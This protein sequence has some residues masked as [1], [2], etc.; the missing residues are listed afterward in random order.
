VSTAPLRFLV[1]APRGLADL[2]ARE[3]VGLGASDA[4]ER[5][6]GVTFSGPLAVAY[7]ACLW[8][9]VA[10]RVFLE[11][12]R[13]DAADAEVFYRAVRE[14][15]WTDHVGP[16]ATLACDFS[17]HHPA[18]T[19]THFGALKLKDAI[20]DSVRE[21]RAWRP[22][23]ELERPSVRVH[24][25]ANGT[26][27]TL[28]LDLSGE[29]LHRRGYRGAAGE[30]PLKENVAAGVLMRAGWA[31]M[32][33]QG[34]AFLDPM[35]GSGTFVIEAALIAT[36]R[37]PG[38]DRDYFGFLGWAGHDA[39]VWRQVLEDARARARSGLDGALDRGLGGAL[40]GQD[41]DPGAIR[42]A[43]ANAGRAGVQELVQFD[44][45]ALKDAAPASAVRS[46][47]GGDGAAG[48]GDAG[49]RTGAVEPAAG[50]AESGAGAVESA[51]EAVNSA[52]RAV[53]PASGAVG[54]A[55][56]AV[57]P[58]SGAV[59]SVSGAVGGAGGLV[60]TNPPYGVRLEDRETARAV[61]RELGAVLR[62][63]FQGWSAAVLTGSP[64]FGL[65]LGIRAH[66]T[67]TVWNGAIECR[68]LRMKIDTGSAREPGR[69]GKGDTNLRD[70]P[71]ARMFANRLAKNLKKQQAWADRN[72]I[73][74][75]RLYD[76][77]MPEYAFAI[78]IYRTIAEPPVASVAT[79][80]QSSA[81][82]ASPAR[83]SAPSTYAA[84]VAPQSRGEGSGLTW[85]YVQEYA[86]PSEIELEAVR[87]RRGEALSTLSDVTGVDPD[88]IRIRTRRKTKR[89]EQYAKV[90][91]RS[92][93]HV[94]LEDGLKFVVNFD[95]YL[96]TGLFLDHRKTRARLRAG[97]S[98][99]RFLNLFAYTCTA[100]V[101]AAAGGAASTISVDMS[102]TYLNW[103]QRNF[104]LN[105]LSPERNGLVQAD[106][107]NWLQDEARNRERYDLI[108]IDP[109]TFS[110]SKRMEGVLDVDRDHPALIEG[111]M[112]L[113]AP[114]GL[115]VFSTNSQRFKLDESLTQRYD[116]VDISTKTLPQDF[117]RNPRIHRC[118]EVRVRA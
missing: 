108:F 55:G 10:N 72:G 63:R 82:S 105:G 67:H 22:S 47:G 51:A 61:H 89:G 58:A 30:A 74:C 32:A 99:K 49:A 53:E 106:C 26:Q 36:D 23:V 13:F 100:T 118:F 93:Y 117:E 35:C 48:L 18:I 43:R 3:L 52:G 97:A 86:A 28:S 7:R 54:P 96:D 95:D 110:N 94:V 31:E 85:L 41:R 1:S 92:D 34:A 116:V 76:A 45:G 90:Q 88:R 77:D 103:A 80:M 50:A 65:E 27:I 9:R 81:Q 68:L 60:C 59:G 8:S 104:E 29:S 70:T 114:G 112:R 25:H 57:E 16:E 73:S 113:L 46:R 21:A 84:A 6:T 109:P 19:H 91:D 5:S 78:D 15:D 101:Y 11:L 98:G 12:A 40:R 115:V 69:L 64:E 71:G 17:G 20:V 66:R 2:L 102:N 33:A 14:I 83:N 62:E 107:R 4:R 56:R 24:A 39:E 75:Y 79:G 42:N 38:L 87:R 44:V 111:C 37:A